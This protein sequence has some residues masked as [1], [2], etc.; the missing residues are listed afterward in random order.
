MS[1]RALATIQE[2]TAVD[3]IENADRIERVS[4]QGWH[5]V[6]KKGE[7]KVGDR[8]VYVEIDSI[9]P[10]RPEFD[11]MAERHYKVK[12]IRLRKQISQGIVFP[13][14]ILPRPI[15]LEI[16]TDVTEILGIKKNEPDVNNQN[17]IFTKK[18]RGLYAKVIKPILY[19]WAYGIRRNP[20]L[21]APF[22][23][24]IPKT[25]ETRVQW[26]N[27]VLTKFAG[28]RFYETEKL[29]G[30][31]DGNTK[32]DTT[33]GPMSIEDICKSSEIIEVLT[34]NHDTLEYEFLPISNKLINEKTD[35]WYE[36]EL[37]DGTKLEL[38]SNHPI[39]IDDNQ[40]YIE[41]KN[42]KVGMTT[43]RH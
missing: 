34:L 4:I 10:V 40:C 16:G 24:F 3:P 7:F 36:I 18:D 11:F 21:G 41:A 5:V 9:L 20:S 38:T 22:P 25:D 12:T 6:S 1:D 23:Q 30:C 17:P 15:G 42:V 29:D 14:S 39:W 2:V 26:M 33:V 19:N 35:D 31:L 32:I 13:L 37:E 28:Q 27:A 43:L 8:C